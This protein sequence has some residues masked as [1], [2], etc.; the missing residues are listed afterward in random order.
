LRSLP[1]PSTSISPAFLAC[2]RCRRTVPTSTLFS[3]PD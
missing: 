1:W 2:L 3:R